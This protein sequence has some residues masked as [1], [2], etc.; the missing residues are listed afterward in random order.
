MIPFHDRWVTNE[1]DLAA[2]QEVTA[3]VLKRGVYTLGPELEDFEYRLARHH[4]LLNAVGVGNS[5]DA[6]ELALRAADI[7]RGDEVITVSF[8]PASTVSAIERAGAIP[9]LVDVDPETF[10]MVPEPVIA[11]ITNRTSAIV[12]S[13]RFGQMAWMPP[14]DD[15]AHHYGL[16]LIEDC[17]DALGARQSG[18]Q[19]GTYGR[20]ATFDFAPGST[21]GGFTHAGAI[22]TNDSILADRV[23]RLRNL[24]QSSPGVYSSRGILSIVDEIQAAVLVLRLQALPVNVDRRRTIAGIYNERLEHVTLPHTPVQNRH[25]FSSYVIRHPQRDSIRQHLLR[26]QIETRAPYPTPLHRQPAYMDIDVPGGVL[27]VTDQLSADTL[28]LPMHPS[29]EPHV[30]SRIADAVNE[31]ASALTPQTV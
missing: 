23:R 31:V 12:V 10:T 2:I 4:G 17:S 29:M 15:I 20:I 22:A 1:P 30:A 21:A 14:L 26:N 16:L 5:A 28:A 27:P 11:A 18:R 7:G 9:V 24:G 8:G 25:A 13:H 19:I 6:I 3:R